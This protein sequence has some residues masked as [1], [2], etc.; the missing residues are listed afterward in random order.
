[1][2]KDRAPWIKLWGTYVET[3]TLRGMDPAHRWVGVCVM[4]LVR[5]ASDVRGEQ[6]TWAVHENDE[7]RT[8]RDIADYASVPDKV[9]RVAIADFVRR[10]FM[11]LR[12]DGAVGLPKFWKYQESPDA[13]R[14]REQRVR[15][16]SE[17]MSGPLSQQEDRGQRTEQTRE[18]PVVPRGD[19]QESPANDLPGEESPGLLLT[20]QTP[21]KP[22]TSR[23][24]PR[25]A[26]DEAFA[27]NA[28]E[29]FCEARIELTRRSPQGFTE[30]MR[31]ELAKLVAACAPT[32]DDWR[33]AVRI[34][35]AMDRRGEG[36]GSLTWASLTAPKNFER[37]A[38]ESQKTGDQRAKQTGRA[39]VSS[40]PTESGVID[41]KALM[42]AKERS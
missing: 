39:P 30:T 29:A 17:D 33:G 19:E 14:K 34:R 21:S 35:L 41:L 24:K 38:L 12:E 16:H 23:K 7:P 2:A 5:T 15:G 26:V 32:I 9:A 11:T 36:F 18:P 13:K 4:L 37:W 31:D 22:R 42:A 1:V 40:H 6:T 20:T 3:S 25:A 28:Y 27:Q 8:I 10:G